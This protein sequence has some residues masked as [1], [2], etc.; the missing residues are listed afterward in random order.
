MPSQADRKKDSGGYSVEEQ[1]DYVLNSQ[2][3]YR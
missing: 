2:A 3:G 1:T